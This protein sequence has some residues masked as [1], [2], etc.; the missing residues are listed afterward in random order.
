MPNIQNH[1]Q[2]YILTRNVYSRAESVKR[3]VEAL[4]GITCQLADTKKRKISIKTK[5]SLQRDAKKHYIV[6]TEKLTSAQEELSKVS[7]LG[8]LKHSH[9]IFID[10]FG[11]L[12]EDG[13]FAVQ[14]LDFS[15]PAPKQSK[16]KH[17]TPQEKKRDKKESEVVVTPDFQK[18]TNGTAYRNPTSMCKALDTIPTPFRVRVKARMIAEN[19]VNIK[20]RTIR[21]HFHNFRKGLQLPRLFGKG[22]ILIRVPR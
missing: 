18:P 14:S 11:E 15:S 13:T 5:Q 16:A 20:E 10:E 9:N 12:Q 6:A 17:K 1:S 8:D 21:E 19:F 22:K 3:D 4:Y 2:K 7:G